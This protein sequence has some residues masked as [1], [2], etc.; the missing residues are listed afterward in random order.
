MQNRF[1]SMKSILPFL[2]IIPPQD[3]PM[4]EE[5]PEGPRLHSRFRKTEGML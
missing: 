1:H 3:G 5:K 2:Q 4:P